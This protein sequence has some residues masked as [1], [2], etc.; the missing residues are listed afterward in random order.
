MHQ[1]EDKCTAR[2]ATNTISKFV[3]RRS[4][5]RS[6]G[7]QQVAL[8]HQ[9]CPHWSFSCICCCILFSIS[10]IFLSC[11]R[12]EKHSVNRSTAVSLNSKMF[13][14]HMRSQIFQIS[15]EDFNIKG[16]SFFFHS[17]EGNSYAMMPPVVYETC[18]TSSSF[19]LISFSVS[20]SGV[21]SGRMGMGLSIRL[22]WASLLRQKEENRRKSEAG[23]VFLE[24][25]CSMRCFK[26]GHLLDTVRSVVLV[27]H[28][29]GHV[30]EVVHVRADQHVPQLH[31]VAVR[32]VL[33][34]GTGRRSVNPAAW[35]AQRSK[36]AYK[37]SVFAVV[38]STIPQG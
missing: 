31:K 6:E 28:V 1:T 27:V 11:R 37:S 22:S 38:P 35:T 15:A 34:W 8:R 16:K 14:V 36:R 21:D 7:R 25:F 4:H 9:L 20:R 10:C 2:V 17:W 30:F 32:L 19:I 5:C 18:C 3:V 13:L 33:H 12:T 26:P 24:T 23:K 29:A